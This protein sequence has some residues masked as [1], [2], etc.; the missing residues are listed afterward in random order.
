MVNLLDIVV[1]LKLFQHQSHVFDIFLVGQRY[2]IGRN[3]VLFRGNNGISF[4][5]KR[6]A[7][8]GYIVNLRVYFKNTPA[9]QPRKSS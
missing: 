5:F 2:V 1:V 6:F 4:R 9:T 8:S 7:D 3:L